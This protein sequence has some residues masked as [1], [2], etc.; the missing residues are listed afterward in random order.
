[1]S[2]DPKD[3]PRSRRWRYVLLGLGVLLALLGMSFL[4]S[5]YISDSRTTVVVL[6]AKKQVAAGTVIRDPESFFEPRTIL[7][8][9]RSANMISDKWGIGERGAEE[10]IEY[11]EGLKGCRMRHVLDP[12]QVLT[13]DYLMNYIEAGPGPLL[14]LGQRAYAMP[15]QGSYVA[16]AYDTFVDVIRVPPGD[17]KRTRLLHQVRAVAVDGYMRSYTTRRRDIVAKPRTVTLE[18]SP[19]QVLL[20]AK[21][22]LTTELENRPRRPDARYGMIT[23]EAA[24]DR[25]DTE[26]PPLPTSDA[27]PETAAEKTPVIDIRLPAALKPRLE[28]QLSAGLQTYTVETTASS[29]VNGFIW[30]GSHVDVFHT[31]MMNDSAHATLLVQDALVLAVN[32]ET[33]HPADRVVLEPQTITLAVMPTQ[34]TQLA[35]AIQ[36]GNLRFALRAPDDR[37]EVTRE[38]PAKSE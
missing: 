4:A 18:L 23:L 36:R 1:M 7:W 34:A 10:W 24:G 37:A 15:R 17:G 6:V 22:E 28:K 21:A 12:G 19:A 32:E 20:L 9:D 3:A 26:L 38:G 16:L 8:R 30:P 11:G 29:A 13:H 35:H 14:S 31:W 33:D 27:L 5:V 25:A 2:N